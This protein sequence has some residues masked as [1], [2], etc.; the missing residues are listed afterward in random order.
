[1][2]CEHRRCLWTQKV[3][4]QE[5]WAGTALALALPRVSPRAGDT[6]DTVIP[7]SVSNKYTWQPQT[8]GRAP[9]LSSHHGTRPCGN[10]QNECQPC[11]DEPRAGHAPHT[12][13]VQHTVL[14]NISEPSVA[15]WNLKIQPARGAV[16]GKPGISSLQSKQ[17][18]EWNHSSFS[19]FFLLVFLFK[20]AVKRPLEAL[21]IS[22]P[23]SK[24]GFALAEFAA[25]KINLSR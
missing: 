25:C 24:A 23:V 9:K 15:G 14:V 2:L 6:G 16:T 20:A 10:P 18:G 12:A 3:W 21:F 22:K 17:T 19:I 4:A 1:M 13:E 7:G 5:C 8:L 11:T